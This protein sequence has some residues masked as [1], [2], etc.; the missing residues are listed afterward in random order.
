MFAATY[1][2]GDI[3]ICQLTINHP[4]IFHSGH[5]GRQWQQSASCKPT[6]QTC[7]YQC[8]PELQV[9]RKHEFTWN[10]LAKAF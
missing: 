5:M 2:S 10:P 7:G 1:A 3:D 4:E 6:K 8:H 9:M